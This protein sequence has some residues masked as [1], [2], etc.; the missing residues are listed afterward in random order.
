MALTIG[1]QAL[2]GLHFLLDWDIPR[3]D[4]RY[5]QYLK[6]SGRDVWQ[7]GQYEG[8]KQYHCWPR[9]VYASSGGL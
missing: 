5:L 7:G 9:D 6:V 4:T 1:H 8:E 2:A 3:K